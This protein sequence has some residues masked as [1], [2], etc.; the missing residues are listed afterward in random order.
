[1]VGTIIVQLSHITRLRLKLI[2]KSEICWSLL[3]RRWTGGQ[4]DEAKERIRVGGGILVESSSSY[5]SVHSSYLISHDL[6]T[7][8]PLLLYYS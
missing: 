6:V 3:L 5:N 7:L 8:S 2:S 4:T 1:M